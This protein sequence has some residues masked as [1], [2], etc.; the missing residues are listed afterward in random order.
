MLGVMGVP[1]AGIARW[2]PPVEILTG[3]L[4]IIGLFTPLAAVAGFTLLLVF[5]GAVGLAVWRGKEVNCGCFG[6]ANKSKAQ[7]KIVYR[8]L[9]LMAMLLP[10]LAGNGGWL[11]LLGIIWLGATVGTIFTR[12][13]LQLQTKTTSTKGSAS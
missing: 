8:N 4:L 12:S 3:G 6:A 7:W 13:F 2:L 10:A 5:A 11:A 1:A 9:A